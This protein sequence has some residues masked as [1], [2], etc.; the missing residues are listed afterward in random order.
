ME[1]A[2]LYVEDLQMSHAL[3]NTLESINSLLLATDIS[4]REFIIADEIAQDVFMFARDKSLTKPEAERLIEKIHK[5]ELSP[6]K[7]VWYRF[8]AALDEKLLTH[9][10][11]T[12]STRVTGIARHRHY[13]N[14]SPNERRRKGKPHKRALCACR[15]A[16]LF[17]ILTPNPKRE[18][19][20]ETNAAPS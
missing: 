9:A 15:S 20:Q 17:A 19:Q 7:A 14:R 13:L 16:M 11:T 18:A 10:R 5:F 3:K 12:S 8:S 2:T 4:P 1:N 6:L